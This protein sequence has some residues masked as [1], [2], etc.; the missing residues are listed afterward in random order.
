VS[1]KLIAQARETGE[2]EALALDL[3]DALEAA[4]TEVEKAHAAMTHWLKAANDAEAERDDWKLEAQRRGERSQELLAEV[5]RL[6]QE[7]STTPS[8]T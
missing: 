4:S 3:A 2:W 6:K 5:E 1:E 8:K 7:Y